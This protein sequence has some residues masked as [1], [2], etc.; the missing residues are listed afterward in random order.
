MR[1]LH[2]PLRA[3]RVLCCA[4]VAVIVALG[5]PGVH[6]QSFPSQPVRMI[7]ANPPGG[8]D[9]TTARKISEKLAASL[10]Q[11]VIVENHPGATG[12][13]GA[14]LAAKAKPDGHTLFV[15]NV[16]T[17]GT[18]PAVLSNLPYDPRRSFAPVS[19]LVRG[20]P[21]L[22]VNPRLP[23]RTVDELIAYAKARPGQ[24][25]YGSFG[26]GSA[27]H[28]AME[29]FKQQHGLYIV[30]IPY[31]GGADAIT[32]LIGGRT[33]MGLYYA[34]M[35]LQHVQ[36]GR[37]RALAV[38]GG[39]ARKP[40]LP[41]VPT[42]AELGMPEFDGTGW[43]GIVVP[44]GTPPEVIDLLNREIVAAAQSKEYADWVVQI[45]S[46]LLA[47]TPAA[48]GQFIEAELSRWERVAKKSGVRLD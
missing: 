25:S 22:V 26:I 15:A 10:G 3:A 48:F 13:I 28:L 2:N 7:V 24:L 5:H 1:A 46:D 16:N 17:F 14:G 45:G 33:D 34:S 20:T 32:D 31:K 35:S 37:L 4:A 27:V 30:H 47:G 11:P 23:V 44:A 40:T 12:S 39:N 8:S 21:I 6:A 9:D 19:G 18:N 41:E 29:Q 43:L 42:A 36:A 38:A